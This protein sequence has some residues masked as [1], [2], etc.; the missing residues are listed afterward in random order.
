[1]IN[2]VWYYLKFFRV[3]FKDVD[4]FNIVYVIV[5]YFWGYLNVGCVFKC[6]VKYDYSEYTF[7]KL[8]FIAKLVVFFFYFYIYNKFIMCNNYVYN[9]LKLFVF[10]IF[11]IV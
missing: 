7:N 5:I 1:M 11:F 8:M 9:E 2:K 6:I 3:F 4:K 10:S